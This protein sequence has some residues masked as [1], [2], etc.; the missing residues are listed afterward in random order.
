MA[1]KTTV[2]SPL[3]RGLK[4]LAV[5]SVVLFLFGGSV[6]FV[7]AADEESVSHAVEELV[8][9][10]PAVGQWT[11]YRI[12]YEQSGH[13]TT[14]REGD[15]V[16]MELTDR[17]TIRYADGS[18]RPAFAA[19]ISYGGQ[20]AHGNDEQ[21]RRSYVD[22]TTMRLVAIEIEVSV[23]EEE[24][25]RTESYESRAIQYPANAAAAYGYGFGEEWPDCLHANL[26]LA[27]DGT[28]DLGLPVEC[29]LSASYVA[30]QNH[31]GA[32]AV[33]WTKIDGRDAFQVRIVDEEDASK[34]LDLWYASG[35]P[36]ALQA[37]YS[38]TR[39]DGAA[40]SA[41]IRL[42]GHGVGDKDQALT[43]E[44]IEPRLPPVAFDA[45]QD[46]R[47]P[48]DSDFNTSFRLVDAMEIAQVLPTSDFPMYLQTHPDAYAFS[49]YSHVSKDDV[50]TNR[51]WL[52]SFRAEDP[53]D[54]L[55]VWVVQRTPI[56]GSSAGLTQQAPT[57][58]VQT[59]EI[60]AS[61]AP[62]PSARPEAFPSFQDTLE[63]SKVFLDDWEVDG[64]EPSVWG[65]ISCLGEEC[66]E[67]HLSLS[68]GEERFEFFWLMDV[69]E[70]ILGAQD[71]GDIRWDWKHI[72]TVNGKVLSAHAFSWSND[73]PVGGPD[74]TSA[75]MTTT[76]SEATLATVRWVPPT[77]AATGISLGIAFLSGLAYFA[78]P[79]LKQGAFF[80]LFSRL[81]TPTLLDHPARQTIHDT[82]RADPGIRFAALAQHTGLANGTLRH[83]LHMLMD[84][85][86]ITRRET[87]GFTC[88]FAPRDATPENAAKAGALQSDGARTVLDFIQGH[89]GT[90]ARRTAEATGLAVGTVGY[91]IK[92]LRDAGLIDSARDGRQVRLNVA[93]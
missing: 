57:Y 87:N 4:A 93:T 78:W 29:M 52:V 62:P 91:H 3:R 25:G 21:E 58:T 18:L 24:D 84:A 15:L 11:E 19:N 17:T 73:A 47:W 65:W 59:V 41:R 2:Q 35:V 77:P 88:Y 69:P 92:K 60:D 72:L 8:I 81:K 39:Q 53:D 75:S 7:Q 1:H 31:S 50:F 28:M 85:G 51:G 74:E 66:D 23:Q 34:R 20:P 40:E 90:T 37:H 48:D 38:T 16:R 13:F 44:I 71:F 5:F 33:G 64:D 36:T 27:D 26:F 42:A 32:E 79:F 89:P 10:Y 6:G 9:P 45:M 54:G 61:S 76:Q 30:F 67:P 49:F 82:V 12:Q 63:W 14:D 46:D 80:G 56:E 83:H 68:V 70:K 55:G 86:L 43:E 22:P